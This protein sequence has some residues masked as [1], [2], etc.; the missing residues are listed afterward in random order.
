MRR[1][2]SILLAVLVGVSMLSGGALAQDST[3]ILDEEV[4]PN[5]DTQTVWYEVVAADD[6]GGDTL[7]ATVTFEGLESGQEAGNGTQLASETI[8][9]STGGEATTGSY[10]LADSDAE[11]Y[12]TI[13][14]EVDGDASS[15]VDL[16]NTTDYGTTE[17]LSGGGGGILPS[18]G[19]SAGAVVAV[20]ALLGIGLYARD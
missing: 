10:S 13:R 7:N 4:S 5:D 6:L 11:R 1:L 9:V 12:E 17:R 3:T 14:I 2:V 18:T 8:S 15:D 20:L 19:S 16:V